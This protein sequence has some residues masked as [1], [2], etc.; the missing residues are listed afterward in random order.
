MVYSLITD[1]SI[2]TG[3]FSQA[4]ADLSSSDVGQ[5]LSGALA[6][7]AE[8]EKKAQEMQNTQAQEDVVTIMS[9]GTVCSK[10]IILYD[11]LSWLLTNEQILEQRMS[12]H[13]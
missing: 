4:I 11:V 7:L 10:F 5:Q 9:T 3:E 8:V 12:M 13:G 1:L 6:G 2:A